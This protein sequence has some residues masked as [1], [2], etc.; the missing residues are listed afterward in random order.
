M[1]KKV[2]ND[3]KKKLSQSR[4]MCPGLSE[5]AYI[6]AEYMSEIAPNK[7]SPLGLAVCLA[8]AVR[9][10]YQE[11]WRKRTRKEELWNHLLL[12]AKRIRNQAVNIPQIVDVIAEADFAEEFRTICKEQFNFDPPRYGT[13]QQKEYPEYVKVAVDWWANAIIAPKLDTE[14]A[15]ISSDLA[16]I[17][18]EEE[19]IVSYLVED[20][21]AFKA[22]L[23]EEI[24]EDMTARGVC[25]LSVDYHPC[26][27]LEAAGKKIG[28]HQ[29]FGYPLKTSMTIWKY[30]VEVQVG[31]GAERKT[32]WT[33]PK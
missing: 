25:T 24:M 6:L 26:E 20:I 23:A 11:R 31:Y 30:M 9:D 10:T 12:D 28:V 15:A 21:N 16:G 1:T 13:S 33:A 5:R 7:T 3:V 14:G 22:T 18:E 32:L 17:I 29:A 4:E 2:M 8:R 19:G 27:A